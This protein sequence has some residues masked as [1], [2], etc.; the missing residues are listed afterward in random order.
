[1]ADD[2]PTLENDETAAAKSGVTR[3]VLD[4]YMVAQWLSH[5][6]DFFDRHP[7]VFAGLDVSHQDAGGAV[8]LIERQ[9][10]VLREQLGSM[11]SRFDAMVSTAR[12]NE[13]LQERLH[14][15]SVVVASAATLDA[16][17][18][19]IPDLLKAE[20]DI[21]HVTLKFVDQIDPTDADHW[22]LL[23][24]RVSH[25]KSIC[26]DRLPARVLEFLFGASSDTV[27]SCAVLPLPGSDPE[28]EVLGVIGLGS[29][30][31][32]RF[33]HAMGT[34]YLDRL[35]EIV[36]SGLQRLRHSSRAA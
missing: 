3:I 34:V 12:E 14:R 24:D 27:S 16:A 2:I 23:H 21:E 31:A 26:D 10:K 35:G 5:H 36:S 4:E 18:A 17:I 7:D 1:M 30:D 8:S 25:G 11:Q 6:P 33:N 20:F 29:D 13:V 22:T 15:I 28:R 32:S 9:V 19:T